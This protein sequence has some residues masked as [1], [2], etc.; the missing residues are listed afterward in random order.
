MDEKQL[1]VMSEALGSHEL[2]PDVLRQL[3]GVIR[4]SSQ[5]RWSRMIDALRVRGPFGDPGKSRDKQLA[6]I[7]K[8]VR[9]LASSRRAGNRAPSPRDW[10]HTCLPGWTNIGHLGTGDF[11][12]GS[13]PELT[14]A[15]ITK[16]A[17]GIAAF[18]QV[19]VPDRAN[20]VVAMGVGVG[21]L[22]GIFFENNAALGVLYGNHATASLTKIFTV[23]D[24]GQL[25]PA[26]LMVS[27]D[28][29]IPDTISLGVSYEDRALGLTW[30]CGQATLDVSLVKPG[31]LR[32]TPG[33]ILMNNAYA[34][35][36]EVMFIK[37]SNDSVTLPGALGDNDRIGFFMPMGTVNIGAGNPTRLSATIGRP[38]AEATEVIV[39][40]TVD[41]SL[42]MPSD[43][44]AVAFVDATG[45]GTSNPIL[46]YPYGAASIHS[47][48][49]TSPIQIQNIC[50]CGI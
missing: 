34:S 26:A 15:N 2:T 38:Y 40:V 5:A 20:G 44:N 13:E 4:D 41:V 21:E 22:L 27:A 32:Q 25:A 7:I 28:V 33:G 43:Q 23:G 35:D 37:A 11:S 29:V 24:L 19:A 14:P 10:S 3:R 49:W 17:P 16:P 45:D 48:R 12:F 31:T 30:A 1:R 50:V 8:G 9:L 18:S 36:T 42:F 39:T 46:E 47:S 6:D